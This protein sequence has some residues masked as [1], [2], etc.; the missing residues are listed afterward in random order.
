MPKQLLIKIKRRLNEEFSKGFKN[1]FLFILSRFLRYS[2][3]CY[4]FSL[5]I[6]GYKIQFSPLAIPTSMF[7]LGD[8]EPETTTFLKSYL[9]KGDTYVD[10]GANVGTTTLVGRSAV[11]DTGLVFCFEPNKKTYKALAHNIRKNN[12]T[13]IVARDVALGDMEKDIMFLDND[14]DDMNAVS[15]DGTGKVVSM[16]TLDS[17]TKNL[18]TIHLLKIDVEGYEKY[19]F[20]GGEETLKKTNAVFFEYSE[21][22]YSQFKYTFEEIFELLE[23][24]GFEIF[25]L[26]QDLSKKVITKDHKHVLGRENLLAVRK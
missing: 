23:S 8:L 18:S 15:T 22:N 3:L 19:V 20:E 21:A 5:E 9:K 24:L 26:E 11:G 17:F 25:S 14:N 7:V 13:N 2:R 4:F 10:I 1:L 16:Y 6:G 12:L